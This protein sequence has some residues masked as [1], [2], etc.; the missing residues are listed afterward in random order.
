MAQI[1]LLCAAA[2]TAVSAQEPCRGGYPRVIV[3]GGVHDA[4]PIARTLTHGCGLA[5]RARTMRRCPVH[6]EHGGDT[7]TVRGGRWRRFAPTGSR[8]RGAAPCA[9]VVS[10]PALPA[11]YHRG[12]SSSPRRR[13]QRTGG[14][15]LTSV[16]MTSR[17]HGHGAG[18][19]GGKGAS[20]RAWVSCMP[21][22]P[23]SGPPRGTRP[24]CPPGGRLITRP[25]LLRA[26]V[27]APR[28]WRGCWPQYATASVPRRA[29]LARAAR[30]AA[31]RGRTK[32]PPPA[33]PPNDREHC[34]AGAA[35]PG[36]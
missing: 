7:A 6:P 31:R 19:A 29:E 3:A 36:R 34:G 15:Q 5:A 33:M 30:W 9:A 14:Q 1:H 11:L 27:I 23:W 17:G 20:C 13:W 28:P 35:K 16:A 26:R 12:G 4:R 25:P 10:G 21:S 22:R 8:V 2:N 32:H 24:V 18:L